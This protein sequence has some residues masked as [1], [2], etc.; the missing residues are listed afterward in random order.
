VRE[1][2]IHRQ[3]L[4]WSTPSS[5]DEGRFTVLAFLE[6]LAAM[7]LAGFFIWKTGNL[8]HTAIPAAAAPLLL[9]RTPESTELGFVL[10]NRTVRWVEAV[11][12]WQERDRA[13]RL[14]KE[15]CLYLGFV[16][17]LV[18]IP[19]I[20]V[21][22]RIMAIVVTLVRHPITIVLAIPGNWRRIAMAIDLHHPPEMIPG[23]ET[24]SVDK[25][26]RFQSTFIER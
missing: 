1:G 2:C 22:I 19:S 20:S 24:A 6:T 10:Y 13:N 12:A 16:F 8:L 14:I 23:I 5:A 26:Y 15:S 21:V 25:R 4:F 9:L 3:I 18:V 7:F 11:D 17:F